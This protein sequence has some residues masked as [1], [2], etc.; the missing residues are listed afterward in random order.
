MFLLLAVARARCSL[1]RSRLS[2]RV[3]SNA[4]LDHD[5]LRLVHSSRSSLTRA[6]ERRSHLVSRPEFIN[7]VSGQRFSLSL[8]P[9]RTPAHRRCCRASSL[10]PVIGSLPLRRGPL[11]R[12]QRSHFKLAFSPILSPLR[13]RSPSPALVAVS[14]ALRSRCASPHHGQS[15]GSSA[16]AADAAD[17]AAT[18]A[19]A[20]ATA[21]TACPAR[22]R[23]GRCFRAS[24]R[25]ARRSRREQ[26][27]RQ[28]A[29]AEHVRCCG[30]RR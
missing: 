15:A 30:S 22:L 23:A 9:P 16:H 25:C 2:L 3:R 26:V 29:S 18:H 14:A 28:T 8:H 19:A 5:S 12:R 7:S 10:G 4:H 1:A 24:S 20:A 13:R 11:A 27:V 17:A 6:R 21:A